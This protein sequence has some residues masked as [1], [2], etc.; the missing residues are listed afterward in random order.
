MSN[1]NS[2]R[3]KALILIIFSLVGIALSGLYLYQVHLT[4]LRERRTTVLAGYYHD[5]SYD[6]LVFLKPNNIYNVSVLRPKENF[7]YRRI[8]DFI[9]FNMSYT[10]VLSVRGNGFIKYIV[11]MTLESSAGWEKGLGN[12]TSGE[13]LFNGTE[14]KLFKSFRIYPNAFW[15]LIGAI[16][17]ETGT[18]SSEYRIKIEP[19]IYVHVN[20]AVGVIDEEY[21]PVMMIRIKESDKRGDIITVE[22]KQ[23]SRYGEI[24]RI[25]IIT[26]DYL[27]FQRYFSYFLVGI[28]GC[29]F[30]YSS[31]MFT[32]TKPEVKPMEVSLNPLKDI[33]ANIDGEP[34]NKEGYTIVKV[35]ALE[36]LVK[37]SDNLFK[38]ILMARREEVPRG[39][40][41]FTL[42]VID[43]AIRY[44]YEVRE[45]L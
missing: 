36:D 13:M 4:P 35:A 7:V 38:P 9:D 29:G 37:I 18:V 14:C 27:V 16:E 24:K 34:I 10:F 31:L 3:G 42:Y 15:D 11:N 17:K 6:Y 22:G 28:L 5:I 33:L 45:K 12:I 20:T 41:V 39:E 23:D 32:R 43:G 25:D 44:E 19:N 40:K 2:S 26:R 21:S 1:V 8:T 30:A